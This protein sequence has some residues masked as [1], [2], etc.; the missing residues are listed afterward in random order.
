MDGK[1]KKNVF[2]SGAISPDFIASSIAKHSTKTEI[3]AHAIF[4]GQVRNDIVGHQEVSA[5]E[6]TSYPEMAAEKMDEIREDAFREFPLICMHIYHSLGRIAAGEIS[7]FVFTS[8]AHRKA[9]M[10]ACDKIVERIKNEV[11]IWGKEIFTDENYQWKVN[12]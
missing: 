6:Y 3:G 1:K 4:L 11:P 7:L 12:K 9:A 10:Q 8:S 2:V 5:I